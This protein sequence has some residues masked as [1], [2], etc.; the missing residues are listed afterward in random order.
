MMKTLKGCNLVIIIAFVFLG[1]LPLL[2]FVSACNS[3]SSL[4]SS[5]SSEC[6]TLMRDLTENKPEGHARLASRYGSY[7]KAQQYFWRNCEGG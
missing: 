1:F 4:S 2:L 7:D 6:L 3:S 5:S